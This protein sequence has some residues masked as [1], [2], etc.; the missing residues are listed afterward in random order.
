ME[1]KQKV[2]I[3]VSETEDQ[4]GRIPLIHGVYTSAH[5]AEIELLKTKELPFKLN[6]N[7]KTVSA[8]IFF[9]I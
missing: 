7:V 1:Y 8:N 2:I 9:E 6:R 5:D 3:V 4:C